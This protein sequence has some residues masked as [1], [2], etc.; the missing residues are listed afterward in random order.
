MATNRFGAEPVD[1]SKPSRFGASLVEQIPGQRPQ[2]AEEAAASAATRERF[3]TVETPSMLESG[4]QATAALPIV[5]GAAKAFQ[6]ASRG[7]RLAPYGKRAAE[8]FIPQSG[9]DL[10]R[11][12]ALTF[13]GGATAQGASNMLPQD[14]GAFPRFLVETGTGLATEGLLSSLRASAR[15]FRPITPGGT[16]RAG[17]RV[18]RQMTPEEIA[19]LPETVEAKTSL[20]RKAQERLRDKPFDQPIDAA[21][22]ARLLGAESVATRQRGGKLG[23]QLAAGTEQRLAAISQPRT[24]EAVGADARKLAADRLK[25]LRDDR[26]KA[27]TINKQ[28]MLNEAR[29]KELAGQGVEGTRAFKNLEQAL[30]AFER[31]P[32]TGRERITGATKAQ[33]D[34]VR[35]EALGVT[36]DPL[37]GQTAKA[38]VGFERLE[39]LRR[40]LGDRGAGLPDTGFDAIGQQDAKDL[41][42]L[43]ENI[44]S[45]FTGK[46]FDK[47]RSDYE[48]LSQPIN[49]FATDV[50]AALTAPSPKVRGEMVTQAS[51][52]PKKIFSTPENIDNFT[53]L[54]G[55]DK[56]AVE[57]LARNYASAELAEK[58]P[59]QIRN[60]LKTNGEWLSRF[61][62]L[63]QDFTDYAT[64]LEQTGR[65]TKKLEARTTKRAEALNLGQ[66]P[67]EQAANFKSLVMSTDK[68]NELTAAARVLG[69]TPEGTAAFKSSV[70]DLIGTLSPG[71]ITTA[72]RDRIKPAM[73][74]SGLYTPDELKFVDGAIADIARIQITP[75][76][77]SQNIGTPAGEE[78]ARQ[79]LTRLIQNEITEMKRGTAIAGVYTAGLAA[80][81]ARFGLPEFGFGTGVAATAASAYAYKAYNNYR[82]NIRAAVSDI[83]TDPV[84]LKEVLKSPPDKRQGV[85]ARMIRQTVGTQLGVET[86][87]RT[88][89][90]PR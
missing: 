60:W 80:L 48:Q 9:S 58:S 2:T 67:A 19:G 20:V 36:Y 41:K 39:Q 25:T 69:K 37:T 18:V 45:E 55:G 15:G 28:D 87:E 59:Q 46:K 89:N 26:E 6:L 12:A 35:R 84:K 78:T 77:A 31:D 4:L 32:I 33:F 50:G 22:V 8:M 24:M 16:Q 61:P 51:A 34:E 21:D 70:R 42:K 3:G 79:E 7:G 43:V 63:K 76:R 56:A 11:Q 62:Q 73:Q 64:K 52:L 83:V 44:M 27:T 90:A 81:A 38:K 54:V 10:A 71:Q 40:R 72:Y 88:E 65:V 30:P 17:E 66:T 23:E 74:A 13:A 68:P 85:L 1:E 82:T 49:Q 57:G 14:T 47:Y 29:T 53:A 86:P 5:G 75:S